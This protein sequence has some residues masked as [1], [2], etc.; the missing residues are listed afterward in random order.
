MAIPL[1]FGNYLA[2][3]TPVHRIEARIKLLLVVVYVFALFACNTWV[4]LLAALT[5]LIIMF[6]VARVPVRM[7]F[8]GL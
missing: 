3:D 8:R 2:R 5:I 7:A 1:P 6:S 4:G